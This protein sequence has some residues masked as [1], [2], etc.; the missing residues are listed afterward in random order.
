[1]IESDFFGDLLGLDNRVLYGEGR[2]V[3]DANTVSILHPMP[4]KIDKDGDDARNASLARLL[5][6]LIYHF[7]LNFFLKELSDFLGR[8]V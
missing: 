1:M 7:D 2:L 5:V 6:Y 3:E 8:F 4:G